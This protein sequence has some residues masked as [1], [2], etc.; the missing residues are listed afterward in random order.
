MRWAASG[1]ACASR[2]STAASVC[3]WRC[4]AA[5][6]MHSSRAMSAWPAA[7]RAP[8]WVRPLPRA[9]WSRWAARPRGGAGGGVRGGR[10]R[11]RHCVLQSVPAP[12]GAG[13]QPAGAGGR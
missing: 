7:M 10:S 9:W 4:A 13:A 12:S 2:S 5:C 11:Q 3:R 8:A 6:S 1:Y